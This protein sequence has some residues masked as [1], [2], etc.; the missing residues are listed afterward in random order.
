MRSLSKAISVHIHT[1]S[2]ITHAVFV[3]LDCTYTKTMMQFYSLNKN[4]TMA[5]FFVCLFVLGL[6]EQIFFFLSWWKEGLWEFCGPPQ[7]ISTQGP[8]IFVVSGQFRALFSI[9]SWWKCL[10]LC[11]EKHKN[12]AM[13]E[14]I[15]VVLNK[16]V[17]CFIFLWDLGGGISLCV[18]CA[19]LHFS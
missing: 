12:Q 11:K 18:P 16:S 13:I 8:F 15:T 1:V 5:W 7:E 4:V 6:L 2:W 10:Y 19:G 14:N 9:Y 17:L 3:K